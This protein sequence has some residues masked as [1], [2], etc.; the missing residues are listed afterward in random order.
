MGGRM[1]ET[2]K[3]EFD[4]QV[5]DIARVTRVVSGGKRMRF[6]ALIVIGDRK[7]RVGYGIA[8]GGDV[9][10]AVTKATAAAKKRILTIPIWNETIPHLIRMK[11]G[12]AEVLLKP[13]PLGTGIIAGGPV[14]AVVELAGVKNIVTKMLGARN[15]LNN[16]K[17]TYEAL[18]ALRQRPPRRVAK[19]ADAA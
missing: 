3:S 8:K 1:R 6:R 9:S 12:A 11:F 18:R 16:V 13:A 7:G 5:L 10:L 17:A 4:Q 19:E 15:P 2:E 14:R